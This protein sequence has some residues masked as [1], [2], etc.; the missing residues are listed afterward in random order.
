[1]KTLWGR[2]AMRFNHETQGHGGFASRW[3]LTAKARRRKEVAARCCETNERSLR[4]V[5][6]LRTMQYFTGILQK[7]SIA[8]AR[9]LHL[10]PRTLLQKHPFN[11]S[12]S[13]LSFFRNF[14][15][16]FIRKCPATSFDLHTKEPLTRDGRCSRIQ[17]QLFSIS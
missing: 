3:V 4:D 14:V 13:F 11:V 12:T 17:Q 6:A 7:I 1:M 16:E 10:T 8:A 5:F 2:F 9:T 15:T